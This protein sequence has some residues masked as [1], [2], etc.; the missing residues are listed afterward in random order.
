MIS[1]DGIMELLPHRFP[2]LLVDNVE[3]LEVMEHAKGIK[4]VTYNEPYFQ[5]HFPHKPVM[6]GVLI[7]EALTQL[8]HIMIVSEPK[9]RDNLVYYAG[10]SKAKFYDT[11]RPGSLLELS[12][13]KKAHNDNL[14]VC[15]TSASVNTNVV[16]TAEITVMITE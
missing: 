11:V 16:F 7:I 10:I 4:A 8:I 12:V 14:V 5:G 2:M 1:I 6:P 3:E 15:K 13:N 9:Y